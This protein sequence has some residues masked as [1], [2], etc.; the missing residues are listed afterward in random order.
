MV[1]ATVWAGAT[2]GAAWGGL[3]LGDFLNNWWAKKRDIQ[4]IEEII[5]RTGLD[6]AQR[7]RL[8]DEITRQ[9]LD[10]EEIEQIARGIKEGARSNK[11]D[12]GGFCE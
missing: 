2:I 5:R 4:Q 10:L 11:P 8:H 1:T 3:K 6:R 12:G 7:R 9:G